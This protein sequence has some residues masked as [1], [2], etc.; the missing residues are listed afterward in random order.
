M[1]FYSVSLNRFM[2]PV[3][4]R[5]IIMAESEDHIQKRFENSYYIDYITEVEKPNKVDLILW[6]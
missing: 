1:K 3:Y 4:E 5:K 6:D 2:S